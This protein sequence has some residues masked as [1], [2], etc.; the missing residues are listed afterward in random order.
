MRIKRETKGYVSSK[1]GWE[2][3]REKERAKVEFKEREL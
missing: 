2:E 1:R 3:C